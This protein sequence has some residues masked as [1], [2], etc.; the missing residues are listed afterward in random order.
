[1]T[2]Q[3]TSGIPVLVP[4]PARGNPEILS[5]R[6]E[7]NATKLYK[8]P[9]PTVIPDLSSKTIDEKMDVL[10]ALAQGQN[11]SILT[12]SQEMGKV[13]VDINT[14]KQT[15]VENVTM[16][17]ELQEA[18]GKI[19]RLENKEE[20]LHN[21][22]SALEQKEY[23]KSVVLY[24]VGEYGFE[25]NKYL[26]ET[27]YKF[28]TDVLDVDSGNLFSKLNPAGEIRIDAI[29]RLGKLKLD[30]KKPRPILVQFLTTIGK[31]LVY[32]PG[33]LAKLRADGNTTIKMAEQFTPEI[34]EKRTAQRPLFI[35]YK[36]QF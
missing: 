36:K 1:M 35:S 28:I 9:L 18:A 17:Y 25:S 21:K 11:R 7:A 4:M 20:I 24:N 12:L 3:H 13:A 16:K 19:A 31:E 32:N 6:M 27:V 22:I 15:K 26:I 30:T 8:A 33:N 23:R 14:I 29:Q 5:D 10:I 34:R 2:F